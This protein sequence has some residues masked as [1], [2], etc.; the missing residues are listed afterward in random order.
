M[1]GLYFD[2]KRNFANGLVHTGGGFG[3]FVFSPLFE[4]LIAEYGWRGSMYIEAGICLNLVAVG[5]LM[6]PLPVE[7]IYKFEVTEKESNKC[8]KCN[9]QTF[10]LARLLKSWKFCVFC[11]SQLALII[12]LAI[13]YVCIG[14]YAATMG[15]TKERIPFIFSLIGMA[16]LV[17]K[18]FFGSA[19][20]SPDLDSI[21]V[22]F[23]TSAMVAVSSWIAPF[24]FQSYPGQLAYSILSGLYF[25]G[26]VVFLSALPAEFLPLDLLGFAI[27][28]VLVI[29]GI[30]H[31]IGP[32][33]AGKHEFR[34]SK[35]VTDL[36]HV[37]NTV[38]QIPQ[39]YQNTRGYHD[40]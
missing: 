30:S 21:L 10:K 29:H 8:I 34:F 15:T 20:N 23:G 36:L 38:T 14:D 7:C 32:V 9:P 22:Y 17:G 5:L 37:R 19:A 40:A 25:S 18:L 13:N 11:F 24:L 27:G 28:A 1:T 33:L 16:N 6:R 2:K 3:L 31:Y 12:S 35:Y 4:K 26:P 39:K